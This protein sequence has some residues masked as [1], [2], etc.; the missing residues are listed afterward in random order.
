MPVLKR[1]I[2]TNMAFDIEAAKRYL[3]S[4]TAAMS[5]E[6]VLIRN[7]RFAILAGGLDSY[8]DRFIACLYR[9]RIEDDVATFAAASPRSDKPPQAF[10]QHAS[11]LPKQ[12]VVAEIDRDAPRQYLAHLHRG[13]LRRP[14]HEPQH[15]GHDRL[16]QRVGERQVAEAVL[17]LQVLG[18]DAAEQHG[19]D[20]QLAVRDALLRLAVHRVAAAT[21]QAAVAAR[22]GHRRRT[23]VGPAAEAVRLECVTELFDARLHVP[24][25]ADEHVRRAV[26]PRPRATLYE[27]SLTSMNR[28]TC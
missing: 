27:Q 17:A 10:E 25:V 24:V 22:R 2:D 8:D 16:L 18:R 20:L 11:V 3:N 9:Y 13:A 26:L 7:T 1:V 6:M 28:C 19:R 5:T 21:A 4:K 23:D 15:D 14:L 12:L